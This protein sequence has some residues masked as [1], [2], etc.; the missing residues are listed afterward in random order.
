MENKEQ[1]LTAEAFY[2]DNKWNPPIRDK[3]DRK[4][5]QYS[6]DDLIEFSEQFASLSKEGEEEETLKLRQALNEIEEIAD[7]PLYP[8]DSPY[9]KI[10]QIANNA[11]ALPVSPPHKESEKEERLI[12]ENEVSKM[13]REK[14]ESGELL[15]KLLLFLN[16]M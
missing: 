4:I 6:F 13:I 5:H 7:S 14:I 11:L 3:F 15:K 12:A 8:Q 9:Y 16:P 10:W 1:K 2:K